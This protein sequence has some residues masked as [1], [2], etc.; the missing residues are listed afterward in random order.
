MNYRTMAKVYMHQNP[1]AARILRM[2]Y[3]PMLKDN[4]HVAEIYSVIK[5][6]YPDLDD[7]DTKILFSACVYKMYSPATLIAAGMQNAPS[8]M[9]K[10]IAE[11]LG[12]ANGTNINYFQAIARSYVKNKRYIQKIANI[13]EHFKTRSV[14]PEDWKLAL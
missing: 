3:T 2:N 4:R 10:S 9:R 12:Y 14:N 8:N 11:V 6:K 7:T 5:E 1:E 13:E